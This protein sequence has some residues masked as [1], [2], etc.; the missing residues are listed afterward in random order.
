[1]GHEEVVVEGDVDD[2]HVALHACLQRVSDDAD[3]AVLGPDV[4]SYGDGYSEVIVVLVVGEVYVG[5]ATGGVAGESVKVGADGGVDVDVGDVSA[6]GEPQ[7]AQGREQ[8]Q[9]GSPAAPGGAGGRADA[10][11][12]QGEALLL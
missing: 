3:V 7:A 5:E 11:A 2:G 1:M 4:V 10:R 8:N 6:S 9:G 12:R